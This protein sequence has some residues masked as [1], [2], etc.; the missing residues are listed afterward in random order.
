[1]PWVAHAWRMRDAAGMAVLPHVRHDSGEPPLPSA[2]LSRAARIIGIVKKQSEHLAEFGTAEALTRRTSGF[3][4][5][6]RLIVI[7]HDTDPK[8][9]SP[10]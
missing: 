8:F 5:Y 1:M 10:T 2:S 9:I 3:S 6:V 7:A 4:V